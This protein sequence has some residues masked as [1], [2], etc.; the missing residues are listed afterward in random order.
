MRTQAVV[1]KP[2]YPRRAWVK[3]K[4]VLEPGEPLADCST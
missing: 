4:T 2:G 3:I 1:V